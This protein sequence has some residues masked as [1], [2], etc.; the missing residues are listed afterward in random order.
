M[1]LK[2]HKRV[3]TVT[4]TKLLM[5]LLPLSVI[6]MTAKADYKS[7]IIESCETYQAGKDKDHVN[8]CKLYIDGFIDAA[9]FTENAAL[10]DEE[11]TKTAKEKSAFMQRVY[12]TRGTHR[13]RSHIDDV[14]VEFCIDG[15]AD[16]KLI[17]S[18][19][20]KSLTISDLATKPLKG[21]LFD[22]LTKSF[23]CEK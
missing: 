21:V 11:L 17:A 16:R 15:S 5:F 22:A 19:I 14:N 10:V 12:Q 1:Y 13:I 20:A 7:E 4:T 6:S 8:A 9:I 23:P 3:K 2:L 18:D